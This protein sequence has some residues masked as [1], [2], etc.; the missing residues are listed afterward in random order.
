MNPTLFEIEMQLKKRLPYYYK[1]G[2][3]QND[4]WDALTTFIYETFF[5]DELIPKIAAVVSQ[6]KIDKKELFNYAAN[7]WYN[8]WSAQAVEQIFTSLPGIK[9]AV[10]SKD[11]TK[12]FSISGIDFDHKTTVFPKGFNKSFEYAQSNP[13]ELIQWLYNNQST[14][15]RHHFKNRLFIVVYDKNGDHWKL[16]AELSLLQQAIKK[17]SLNF[18]ADK[19]QKLTFTPRSQTV[20]DLIWVVK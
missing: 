18:N 10:N 13:K 2:R 16:K 15:Q 11:R 6:K 7:R 3:K 9:A 12:D 8:F 14:Q 19:L 5:W 17:Y 4:T 1:W 20:S